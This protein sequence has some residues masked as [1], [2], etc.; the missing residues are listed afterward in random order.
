MPVKLRAIKPKP[1]KVDAIRLETLNGLRK[2]GRG[3]RRDFKRTVQTWDNKPKFDMKIGLTKDTGNVRV[4]TASE[5]YAY[6]DLGTKPHI[7]RPVRAKALA[8]SVGGS[9]KT[10]PNVIGSY[11]GSAGNTPVRAKEV[12]HPGIKPRNFSRIIK[13]EWEPEFARVMQTAIDTG[14][15]KS[16]HYYR[17]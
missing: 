1:F 10:R 8:F 16:G 3:M 11:S 5:I 7:I 4:F 9:P 12:K 15:K 6:V 2:V 14:A 13:K 17:K